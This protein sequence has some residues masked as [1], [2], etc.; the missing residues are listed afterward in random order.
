MKTLSTGRW[1]SQC[2]YMNMVVLWCLWFCGEHASFLMTVIN[3]EK[4]CIIRRKPKYVQAWQFMPKLRMF[5]ACLC[6]VSYWFISE[7]CRLPVVF[8]IPTDSM[9][10]NIPPYHTLHAHRNIIIHMKS[11]MYLLRYIITICNIK[12]TLISWV[13]TYERISRVCV[14]DS[15][16]EVVSGKG[17]FVCL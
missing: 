5:V 12:T 14:V 9:K 2:I 4:K 11:I 3:N 1:T 7:N 6:R 10:N 15:E 16:F 13:N 8:F 17:V